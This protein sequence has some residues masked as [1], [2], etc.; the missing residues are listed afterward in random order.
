MQEGSANKNSLERIYPLDHK[1]GEIAGYDTVVLHEER[2]HWAGKH[3]FPGKIADVACGSGYG[4]YLLATKYNCNDGKVTAIDADMLAI[5]Y[6]KKKY[7]HKGI[8][9]IQTD[10]Y[11]YRPSAMFDTIVSIET[12][13]HL[14]DPAKFVNQFSAYLKKGG[15]FI[16]SAPITPSMDAN[17]YHLHD[18]TTTSFKKL[19]VETGLKEIESFVQ[20]QKFSPFRLFFKKEGRTTSIRK[21]LFKFYFRNPGKFLLRTKSLFVDGFKNKYLLVIFEKE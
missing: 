2:Y 10:I 20:I 16:A 6:A 11:S 12:I 15:K 13:E 17:P 3:I 1:D 8:D 14:N 9:F 5:D 19:F 7:Q 18:F 21:N 4:S